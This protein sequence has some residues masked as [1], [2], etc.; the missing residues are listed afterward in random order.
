MPVPKA[1]MDKYGHMPLW[2]NNVGLTRQA[3][4]VQGI[5]ETS[6]VKAFSDDYLGAGVLCPDACHHA[7]SCRRINH[8]SHTWF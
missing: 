5:S 1:A 3:F 7:A 2:H 8:I 6:C 4:R